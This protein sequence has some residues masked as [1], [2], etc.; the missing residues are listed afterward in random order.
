MCHERSWPA[1]NPEREPTCIRKAVVWYAR[2]M[3]RDLISLN[4]NLSPQ[5]RVDPQGDLLSASARRHGFDCGLQFQDCP[6]I[7]PDHRSD[8]R[9]QPA[10]HAGVAVDVSLR[11]LDRPVAGQELHVANRAAGFVGQACG[12]GNEGTAARM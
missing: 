6:L 2:S 4:K 11:G 3:P 9:D 5:T 8:Q 12:A 7:R 1:A 10:L